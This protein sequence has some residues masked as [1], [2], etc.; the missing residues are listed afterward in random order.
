VEIDDVNKKI[1]DNNDGRKIGFYFGLLVML[2]VVVLQ[3]AFTLMEFF[4]SDGDDTTHD[5]CRPKAACPCCPRIVT[6]VML[7]TMLIVFIMAGISYFASTALADVCVRPDTLAMEFIIG[8]KTAGVAAQ[9]G[10]V[11]QEFWDDKLPYYLQC[12]RYT[13]AD[14][15][16]CDP[17][18]SIYDSVNANFAVLT[19]SCAEM[20]GEVTAASLSD[21]GLKQKL[22]I[23]V[24]DLCAAVTATTRAY[25]V[26]VESVGVCDNINPTYQKMVKHVCTNVQTPLAETAQM[27]VVIAAVMVALELFE[28]LFREESEDREAIKRSGSNEQV[29]WPAP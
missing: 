5:K 20:A 7:F 9:G 25:L 22:A 17:Q 27:L 19:K 29:K 1:T 8:G 2:G 15:V 4:F 16:A 14:K 12:N 28:R 13:D 21:N 3:V 10:T 23:N 26:K 11:E 24:A 6:V 18:A